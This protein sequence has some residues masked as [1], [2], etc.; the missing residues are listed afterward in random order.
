MKKISK[1]NILR[2]VNAVIEIDEVEYLV[3]KKS[4]EAIEA[5]KDHV[6][7]KRLVDQ[8]TRI[9]PLDEINS[10]IKKHGIVDHLT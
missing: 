4:A 5:R 9:F 2:L 3:D 10:A 1:K 8:E 7:L 6:T